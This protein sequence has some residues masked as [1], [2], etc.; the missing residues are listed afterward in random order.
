MTI[1][2]QHPSDIQELFDQ[3]VKSK[4]RLS[5]QERSEMFKKVMLEPPVP[6]YGPGINKVG[7]VKMRAW[8]YL[9]TSKGLF[10]ESTSF[11]RQFG[12]FAAVAAQNSF[13]FQGFFCDPDTSGKALVDL[14]GLMRLILTCRAGKVDVVVVE[15]VDRL[16]RSGFVSLV[17]EM[18]K[19]QNIVLYDVNLG[20]PV[21]SEILALKSLIGTMEV[22]KLA[23][24]TARSFAIKASERQTITKALGHGHMRPYP[25]G[26]VTIHPVGSARVLEAHVMFDSG[27]KVPHIIIHFNK[28]WLAGNQE[29][30]PPG[31]A[32]R[33]V[34]SHFLT[35]SAFDSAILE[36]TD[37]IGEFLHGVSSNK[38]DINTGKRVQTIKRTDHYTVVEEDLAIVP[39]DL[40]KRN[41]ERIAR[42][43][44][45]YHL[46]I[47][48][49]ESERTKRPPR[50]YATVGKGRRLLSGC[51]N[52][53]VCG[54]NHFTYTN[55]GVSRELFMACIGS[56][57]KS[58]RS[59]Y[60]ISAHELTETVLDVL[61]R[62]FSSN[63]VI[64]H[65]KHEYRAAHV[66]ALSELLA[67]E[68][69]VGKE[70]E[71]L[72]QDLERV[73]KKMRGATGSVLAAY[74][75][76]E[77][78]LSKSIGHLE[79]HKYAIKASQEAGGP[80]RDDLLGKCRS[81]LSRLREH[82]TYSSTE[83]EDLWIVNTVRNMLSIDIIPNTIDYGGK[84]V[85]T[86]DCSLFFRESPA[87]ID[88]SLRFEIYIP[89]KQRG[90]RSPPNEAIDFTI[91]E[92]ANDFLLTDRE[93]DDIREILRSHWIR[94]NSTFPRRRRHYD[95]VFLSL[96]AGAG[97]CTT[98]NPN[99]PYTQ[100][101]MINY[102]VRN[103]GLWPAILDSM[104]RHGHDW[105]DRLDPD[106]LTYLSGTGGRPGEPWFITEPQ[107]VPRVAEV[108]PAEVTSA[109]DDVA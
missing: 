69:Q 84:A 88:T 7:T 94:E 35:Y 96:R 91:F 99:R 9:R 33:W 40:F 70:L 50:N 37:Y 85:V 36:N 57:E 108:D 93:W 61:E 10:E 98:R 76:E 20:K 12:P 19:Q 27:L 81:L 45:E 5:Y 106:M 102:W 58:C 43:A 59:Y 17:Y 29:Y 52:C 109:P 89:P 87:Q 79:V 80:I 97:P 22:T 92:R 64:E 26:P 48:A 74:E 78:D 66:A 38:N 6:F 101:C 90:V 39:K 46:R 71:T 53:C 47:A 54:T 25:R 49:N 103:F 104:R 13:E 68:E 82:N 55:D 23:G 41:K 30:K 32:K 31:K 67:S 16:G 65:Y 75:K 105:I 60:R 42:S 56:R 15:D 86:V 83:T 2:V 8:G 21:T 1:H 63:G 95:T 62:L 44:L 77:D 11:L 73:L 28:Q 51:V 3:T 14:V 18:M 24:R 34:W 107:F 100:A 4:E 72:R